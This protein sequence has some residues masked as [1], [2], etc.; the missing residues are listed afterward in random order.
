MGMGSDP[1]KQTL[2]EF[3]QNPDGKTFNGAKLAQ[4]LFA[5]T[6]GKLMSDD[7]AAE[8]IEEAK[9][10]AAAKRAPPPPPAQGSKTR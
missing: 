7:E 6:T 3:C 8:I 5:A 9:R 10:K 2:G 4:W 1:R